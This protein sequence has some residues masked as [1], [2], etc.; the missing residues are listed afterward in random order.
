MLC[1]VVSL[2][3]CCVILC[4]SHHVHGPSVSEVKYFVALLLPSYCRLHH[5]NVFCTSG[6]VVWPGVVVS[7]L[8][9][10]LCRELKRTKRGTCQRVRKLY[11]N[12]CTSVINRYR[13]AYIQAYKHSLRLSDR[14]ACTIMCLT[15]RPSA[16][17]TVATRDLYNSELHLMC[18]DLPTK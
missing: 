3:W 17:S 8:S 16:I 2:L 11:L 10:P 5:L 12:S 13:Q 4:L 14:R 6:R 15:L 9:L 1:C 7:P 18:I